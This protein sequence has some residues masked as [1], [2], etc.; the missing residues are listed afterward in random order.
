MNQYA[1]TGGGP[2]YLWL[3][4][5]IEHDSGECLIW[6]FSCCTAGYGSFMHDK[7]VRLAHREVCRLT[8]GDPPGPRYEAAHSCGN[9]RCVNRKHLSW[10]TRQDNQLD[11]ADHGT[12]TVPGR[13]KIT[14]VQ[15]EQIKQLKGIETSIE[16]AARYGI[17]ESNVRLIQDGKTWKTAGRK[18]ALLLRADQVIAVR[19]AAGTDTQIGRQLGINPRTVT[20]IREGKAYTH[21]R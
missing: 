6:P 8:H 4:A 16:T 1:K 20:R 21:V 19:R 9:R 17:T 14:L 3:M 7:K 13:M 18:H 10:K 12:Q 2:G 11:R 15:A 5:Q